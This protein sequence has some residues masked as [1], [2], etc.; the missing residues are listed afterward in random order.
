MVIKMSTSLPSRRPC[1]QYSGRATLKNILAKRL[2]TRQAAERLGEA[3]E[4]K[5]NQRQ[6][7]GSGESQDYTPPETPRGGA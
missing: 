6:E 7:D 3:E 5:E 4:W 2:Q 1:F